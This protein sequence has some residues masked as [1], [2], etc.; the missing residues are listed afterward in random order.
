VFQ[1]AQRGL[2][3]L[4]RTRKMGSIGLAVGSGRPTGLGWLAS[5]QDDRYTRWRLKTGVSMVMGVG[6][7]TGGDSSRE[8]MGPI[9]RPTM[10]S[11]AALAGVSLTTVSRV[12]NSEPSVS[13]EIVSRVRKATAQLNYH[14]NRTA[15]DLRRRRET[16]LGSSQMAEDL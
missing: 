4:R 2:P 14:P 7:Q 9:E 11:V 3:S 12:F 10:R 15:S 5:T 13:L 1:A 8:Q 6:H 16:S